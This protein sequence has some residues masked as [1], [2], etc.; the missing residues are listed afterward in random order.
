MPLVRPD[1]STGASK[2]SFGDGMPSRAY[3]S[4]VHLFSGCIPA[5]TGPAEHRGCI[6]R[7]LQHAPRGQLPS[8]RC[9]TPSKFKQSAPGLK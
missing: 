7:A 8:A 4:L 1:A 3:S 9:Q 5:Q 6:A 2:P